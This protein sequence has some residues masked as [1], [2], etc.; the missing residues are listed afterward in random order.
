[1]I[2]LGWRTGAMKKNKFT[3]EQIALAL[4]HTEADAPSGP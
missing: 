3:H 1:M 2:G 4:R